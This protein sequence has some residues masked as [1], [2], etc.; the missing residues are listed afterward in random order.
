M[1]NKEWRIKLEKQETLVKEMRDKEDI[2]NDYLREKNKKDNEITDLRQQLED[3]GKKMNEEITVRER[4][5]I[6][7]TEGLRKEMLHKIKE[8]KANL[9]ALNDD[10]L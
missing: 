9:L 10:Q 3:L 7:A 1:N 8:T 6:K 4:E 5:K 2:A